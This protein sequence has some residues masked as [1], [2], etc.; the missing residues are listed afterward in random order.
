MASPDRKV[1]DFPLKDKVVLVTGGGGGQY[2]PYFLL[3][4]V[5]TDIGT[6]ICACFVKRCAD[7]GAKVINA[8][9]RMTPEGKKLLEGYD[10][11]VFQ[12]TDATKWDQ[13]QRLVTISKEK[14]GATPDV[15][16]GGAGVFEPPVTLVT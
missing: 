12:E 14:F 9:L 11:V 8:D 10:N 16:V 13:L 7:L 5:L 6:G 15:Y 4:F 3:I 2:G 1:G